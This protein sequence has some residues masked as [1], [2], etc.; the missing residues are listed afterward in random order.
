MNLELSEE[1]VA[2]RQLARDVVAGEIAPHV[3]QWDR[4]EAVGREI[5]KRLGE[6]GFLGLTIEEE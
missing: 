6:V 4:A 3:A 2:V 1:Q 5:V